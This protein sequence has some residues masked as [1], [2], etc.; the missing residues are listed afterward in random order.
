MLVSKSYHLAIELSNF[1]TK[2][3]KSY[4]NDETRRY[5]ILNKVISYK[6]GG[7]S[8]EAIS[9]LSKEDWSS[10]S[11]KYLLAVFVLKG[12]F[13]KSAQIMKRIGKDDETIDVLAYRE[14]PLFKE[15]R[16]SAEF[17][18]A[19]REVFEEE[20]VITEKTEPETA[21]I[22]SSAEDISTND[23]QDGSDVRSEAP[24]KKKRA[25]KKQNV[26]P[27]DP[28]AVSADAPPLAP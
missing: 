27:A 11:D 24:P 23:P 13:T 18:E 2:D 25:P 4:A 17:L 10:C 7:K 15:F 1:A 22:N 3:I 16:K 26:Q 20:F 6:Y 21:A 19:Y 28:P 14:W 12:E 5:M 9:I 8:E